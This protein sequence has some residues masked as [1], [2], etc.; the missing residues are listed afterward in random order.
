[1]RFGKVLLIWRLVHTLIP[2]WLDLDLAP[3]PS[4]PS[5]PA[6]FR[7]DMDMDRQSADLN[8]ALIPS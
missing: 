7:R 1:M 8:T 4:C 3:L 5:A 2:S 6:P